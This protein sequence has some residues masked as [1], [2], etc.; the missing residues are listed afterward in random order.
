MHYIEFALNWQIIF[1]GGINV[2]KSWTR[3]LRQQVRQVIHFNDMFQQRDAPIGASTNYYFVKL[4]HFLSKR[5]KLQY[6]IK[7]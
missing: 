7:S 6:Q 1:H 2:F 4:A 3:T 5:S